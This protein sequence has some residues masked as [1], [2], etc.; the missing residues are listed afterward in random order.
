MTLEEL[1]EQV[2]QLRDIAERN[3]VMAA[4][5]AAAMDEIEAHLKQVSDEYA[6]CVRAMALADETYKGVEKALKMYF[7]ADPSAFVD[8][9]VRKVEARIREAAVRG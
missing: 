4:K 9:I 2:Q 5:L 8:A 6:A 3:R 1:A 7:P